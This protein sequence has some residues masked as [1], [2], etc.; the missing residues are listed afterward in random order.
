MS[1]TVDT[2]V[3]RMEFDNKQFEK[4]IK[5]TSQSLDN[6]KQNLDFKGVGNSLDEIKV[7]ISALEIAATTFIVN[8]SNRLANLGVMLVKSL[9]VDNI[10]SGWAKFGEK[11][12]S[13]ATMMA[14]K[15][16]IAGEEITDLGLKTE[17]VKF[18]TYIFFFRAIIRITRSTSVLL[19]DII[20]GH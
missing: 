19:L 5:K 20:S 2:R 1:D 7:K 8:L 11:T 4:N 17:V 15:I 10:S 16:R 13:V 14:Q 9:S 3:V 12:T 18:E 6:L